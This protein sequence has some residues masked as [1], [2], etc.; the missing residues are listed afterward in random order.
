[1]EMQEAYRSLKTNGPL[2]QTFRSNLEG[3]GWTFDDVDPT[4]GIGSTDMG[5]VS[6]VAPSIHPYLSIGSQDLVGHSNAFVEA[7]ASD[8][9]FNTMIAA[10]QALAAT[11]VDVLV[12]PDLYEAIRADFGAESS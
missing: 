11:A 6:H 12:K 1:M 4:K 3:M 8:E 7:S 2:A 9:A 5:N 10:A